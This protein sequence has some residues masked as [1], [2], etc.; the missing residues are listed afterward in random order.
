LPSYSMQLFQWLPETEEDYYPFLRH[1]VWSF[2]LLVSCCND[3]LSVQ[4]LIIDLEN[5][6]LVPTSLSNFSLVM[7]YHTEHVLTS[8]LVSVTSIKFY[9]PLVCWTMHM[10][11]LRVLGSIP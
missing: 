1:S 8:W 2:N 6:I 4:F 9:N 10:L 7:C 3:P 11:W 5:H